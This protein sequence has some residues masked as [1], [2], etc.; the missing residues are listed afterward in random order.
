MNA[1]M[2]RW[3]DDSRL[4]G[5]VFLAPATLYIVLLVGLP[6]VTALLFSVSTATVGDASFNYVGLRNFANVWQTPA[7]RDALVN[8]F[9]FTVVA[10]ICTIILANILAQLL[11]TPL[12]QRR[13]GRIGMWIAR[14]LLILPW[15][16]PL[17]LSVVGW[18]WM[19]DSKYSPI[20]YIFRELALLGPGTVWGPANNLIWLGKPLLAKASIIF[21]HV[22][23][24]TPLATVILMAGLSSIPTDLLDQ[25]EVDGSRYFRT[26]F[27]VKL[28]L[29]MPIMLISLL[30]GFIFT[31]GDLTVVYILTR[32]GPITHTLTLPMYSFLV[33]IDGGNLA[34][35]AAVS[36]FIFPVLLLVAVVLLRTASRAEIR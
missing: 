14:M 16:T 21:V 3:I 22:W 7:F 27:Q 20:D 9:S 29:I 31:F 1:I 26:L 11:T 23:R 10:Q 25:A 8:T 4:M 6:F 15:A 30:F 33:G 2:S 28:P 12:P 24:M 5:I 34:Q 17:S 32:G 36:L 35:G 13:S 18:L 19:F